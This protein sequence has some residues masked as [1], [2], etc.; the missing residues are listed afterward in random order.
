MKRS[1][2]ILIFTTLYTFSLSA[3]D[4]R[5]E[6]ESAQLSG[7]NTA[8]NRSG[9]SGTGYV[10]GFNQETD[11]ITF[12]INV[13]EE[14]LYTFK[15]GYNAQNGEKGY[16]LIVN[17]Q[18]S[19]G[20]FS[21][22]NA[23]TYKEAIT[24]KYKLNEG[25]NTVIISNGWGYF[26]I[27]YIDL[28]K[29]TTTK[30]SKPPYVLTNPNATAATK[31]LFGFLLEMYGEKMISGQQDLADIEYIKTQTGKS[32]AIGSFDLI[33][34]SPTRLQYGSNPN[35]LSERAITWLQDG[36]GLGI[37][38]VMWH[39]N[40]PADLINQAP[41]QLWWSGFYTRATTFDLAA[42][43]ADTTSERYQL[44]ISDMDAIAIQLKKF[45]DADIPVLWRPLHEAA[46]AWFWWGAKG[47]DAFKQLWRLMYDR[48]VNHH[49]LDNLIW[50]M[51]M[52]HNMDWYPGDDVVDI[53]GMD[54]YQDISSNMSTDWEV[55][56]QNYNGKKLVALSESGN[57]PMPVNVRTYGT[58][59]SWF[60]LWS[61]DFIRN[62]EIGRLKT[63]YESEC[64][65]T[66]DE[67]PDW[68][69]YVYVPDSTEEEVLTIGSNTFIDSSLK[70]YPN[71]S[72]NQLTVQS[73]NQ[74]F[75]I[76]ILDSVGRSMKPIKIKPSCKHQLSLESLKPGI[77]YIRI[78]FDNRQT[79][80]QKFIK[81]N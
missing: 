59:W 81:T 80:T 24:G 10:T 42:A 49:H 38:N 77:Y 56:M 29:T 15:I 1:H 19:S 64:V 55:M 31:S 13:S 5:F 11:K 4:T 18:K 47:P 72:K 27:D 20:M 7:V 28:I 6:A 17:G 45:K 25:Q 39:W 65:I 35:Q 44:L 78:L 69:N 36:D 58:W 48:Y 57:F 46:G 14:G 66:R 60:S 51:T 76:E 3:A 2:L 71:P 79:S 67:L 33:E 73:D 8:T 30:L 43:L 12:T 52:D 16:E 54:L 37:A 68:K 21:A 63:V 70:I 34:Y 32:P 53:V 75:A 40:A 23:S 61:G 26:D 9:Y 62:Q 50:I 74:I 22:T 41:D